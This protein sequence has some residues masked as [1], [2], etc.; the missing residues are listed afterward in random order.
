MTPVKRIVLMVGALCAILIMGVSSA[1]AWRTTKHFSRLLLA[2]RNG[3]AEL[4]ISEYHKLPRSA[5]EA[6]RVRVAYEEAREKVGDRHGIDIFP[7]VDKPDVFAL[8]I[9]LIG[10]IG[11]VLFVMP[12]KQRLYVREMP[13]AVPDPPTEGQLQFIRRINGGVVPVS[14][15]RESA[16]R[17]IKMHLAKVSARS[18]RQR[19][20]ISP[21]ELLSTSQ[22]RREQMRL[23]RE[24]KRAQEKLQRQQEQ[25]R[26]RIEREKEKAQKVENRLYDRRIAEEERLIRAREE[27]NEGASRKARTPKAIAIQEL[28]NLV[29]DILEDKKIEPQEVRQL[30]AWL[31]ANKQAPTD[32]D[33]MLRIIDESLADGIIDENETQALY[34]GVIDCLLTIRDRTNA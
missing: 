4:V 3:D 16:A 17:M 6:E 11:I 26:R 14:L 5:R 25:E 21:L 1:N 30:K 23:E 34:E 12:R 20:D 29:N 13:V 28:Q 8:F 33:S 7:N 15:T 32:F 22:K 2:V 24:R 9:C 31:L 10:T 19:I 18:S 27:R